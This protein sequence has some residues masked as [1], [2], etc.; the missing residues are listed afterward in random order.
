M[1][2]VDDSIEVERREHPLASEK[3]PSGWRK[4]ATPVLIYVVVI[5]IQ[6]AVIWPIAMQRV[7]D[8]DEGFYSLAAKAVAHGQ[9]PYVDFWFQYPPLLPYVYGGWTRIAGETFDALRALSALLTVVLGTLL[10]RHVARRYSRRLGVAAVLL[11][12]SS[13]LIVIWFSTFKSYALSTLLLFVAYLC[14]A[15]VDHDEEISFPRWLA[16][17]I[18]LGLSVDVRLFFVVLVPVFI[19]YATTARQAMS[20]VRQ[21]RRVRG[22]VLGLLPCIYFF[23]RFP[24]RFVDETYSFA[25]QSQ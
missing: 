16:A 15:D 20:H 24:R 12:V 9:Q 7:L 11:Y 18:F 8:G 4:R 10:F 21:H 3:R 17:G 19:F 5:A 1:T 23:L 6:L 2:T 14:V 22:F 13:A 25:S